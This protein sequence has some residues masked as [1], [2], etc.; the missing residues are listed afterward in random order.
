MDNDLIKKIATSIRSLSMDGVQAA[1]SGHPGLPMGC[2][3]LGAVL[4]GSILR[5][6]PSTPDWINRDRFVLS[7]GHGSM[8]LYSLLYLSGFDVTL[9]D[10]KRFRQ[11]GSKTAGHPE[12]GYI[13]GIETTTGP[14]GQGFSNAV[15]MAIAETMLAERFNTPEH[16][17]IDH[18]TY[19]LSGDGCLMEGVAAEAA[20]LAGHLKLGKLVVFYDSNRITIEGSTDLAFTEDVRKRFEAYG[21]QTLE[22]DGHNGQEIEKLVAR[23]KQ[24]TVKP[25]LIKLNST[26]GFGSPNKA[27]SHDVHGAPLGEAEVKATRLNLGLK[28]DQT[29]YVAPEAVDHFGKRRAEWAAAREKWEALF[30]SWANANP[31]KKAAWDDFFADNTKRAASISFPKYNVGDKQ[32][33]RASSGKALLS[34]AAVYPNIVGGS[35]DL[36]PSNKTD[37]P[38]YGEYSADNRKGQTLHFG[39]REHGMGGVMNG[40]A[41]HSNFKVFGGTF[42]VFS[43]YMRP[44]IR[45]AA[46]MKLPVVYVFTHDSIFVG[47]DG[48]THQ[49]IEHV[50]ALRLI[51]NLKVVRPGDGE[52]TAAAWRLAAEQSD[53]PVALILTRQGL[54]VFEKPSGWQAGFKQGA[55]IAKAAKGT[56]DA[57]LVATGSEVNLALDAAQASGKN[58]QVVSMPCRELFYQQSKAY[59]DS[60]IPEGVKTVAVEAGVSTGWERIATSADHIVSIDRFGESGPA[61]QVAEHLGLTVGAVVAA[62]N[63]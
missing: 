33:T 52:E 25:T 18:Y 11:L 34:V 30:S 16:K 14:L 38:D 55:Y 49:P 24:E 47:E 6:D 9:D 32:A 27:G 54:K 40:I 58:V 12:L 44:S 7:A 61:Q 36:A 22:G 19:A 10:L 2:A 15:G 26:I 50:T 63:R 51:P 46:M 37:M 59:R 62:L 4:Y 8:F 41:L 48:P 13:S 20:S 31:D 35:A 57:V 23:A 56:P 53:A 21:W 3:D 5:L 42:L 60:V 28:E 17:I 1:N 29:F 43:D 45:L 39:V